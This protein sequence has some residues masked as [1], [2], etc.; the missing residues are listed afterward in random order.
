MCRISTT[1]SIDGAVTI[2]TSAADADFIVKG[3]TDEELLY[4]NAGEDKVGI[5]T[6]APTK[7]LDVAGTFGVSM[8][9]TLG[10][11]LNLKSNLDENND[12]NNPLIKANSEITGDPMPAD[13]IEVERGTSTNAKFKWN[14]TSDCFSRWFR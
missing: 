14:E 3:D 1:T 11:I 13:L 4:V 9:T 7:T 6:N 12:V 8:Q 2:N 10:G 5:S